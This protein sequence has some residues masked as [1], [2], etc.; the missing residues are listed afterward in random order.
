MITLDYG[1]P[2]V[3]FKYLTGDEKNI[4]SPMIVLYCQCEECFLCLNNF[5][6]LGVN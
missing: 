2:V 3:I 4:V 5:N 6:I 1:V